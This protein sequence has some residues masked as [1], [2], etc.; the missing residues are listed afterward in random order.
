MSLPF[1]DLPSPLASLADVIEDLT[2]LAAVP[3]R[4]VSIDAYVEVLTV[5]WISIPRVGGTYGLV[6]LRAFELEYLCENNRKRFF[7]GNI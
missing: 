5:L 6:H 2:Q 4:R 1:G 7:I 3:S